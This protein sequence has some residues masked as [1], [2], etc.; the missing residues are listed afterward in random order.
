[1]KQGGE[2]LKSIKRD[3]QKNEQGKKGKD[4]NRKRHTDE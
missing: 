2:R 1:M 3:T 4:K